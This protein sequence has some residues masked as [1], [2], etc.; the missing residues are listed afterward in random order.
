MHVLVERPRGPD[1]HQQHRGSREE[2]RDRL[3]GIEAA[4]DEQTNSDQ[5]KNDRDHQQPWGIARR[6]RCAGI[7]CH[8]ANPT[9]KAEPIHNVSSGPPTV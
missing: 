9:T 6:F 5:R 4:V 8:A 1:H 7:G 2:D 3:L